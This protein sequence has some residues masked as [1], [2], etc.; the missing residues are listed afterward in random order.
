[1]RSGQPTTAMSWMARLVAA[2]LIVAG[3]KEGRWMATTTAQFE[4]HFSRMEMM[5]FWIRKAI[6]RLSGK[7]QVR[8]V[9]PGTAFDL[10]T[11]DDELAYPEG[12]AEDR[13]RVQVLCTTALGIDNV[14]GR[15]NRLALKP[16]VVLESA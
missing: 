4:E 11:M 5:M 3:H 12:L 8:T 9:P 14:G 6:E 10:A 16:K 2:V 13:V 15:E 1:M 7:A